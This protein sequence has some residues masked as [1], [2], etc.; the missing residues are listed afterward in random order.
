MF[1]MTQIQL[2]GVRMAGYPKF[3]LCTPLSHA[4]AAFFVPTLTKG[5]PMMVLPKFYPPRCCA[6]STQKRS[7]WRCHRCCTPR[8]TPPNSDTRGLSTIV[9]VSRAHVCP[10]DGSKAI[11]YR[12]CVQS[13]RCF[14]EIVWCL[15]VDHVTDLWQRHELMQPAALLQSVGE[16]NGMNRGCQLVGRAHET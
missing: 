16:I 2:S 11:A 13:G 12:G 6:P 10:V 5:G 1:T 4:G 14:V 7:P 8:W 3:S 15:H 9:A